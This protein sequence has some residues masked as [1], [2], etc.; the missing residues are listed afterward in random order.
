MFSC[1]FL[2]VLWFTGF[3]G[4]GGFERGHCDVNDHA[5]EENEEILLREDAQRCDYIKKYD[6][7]LT[8]CIINTIQCSSSNT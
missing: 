1:S 7:A 3:E 8:F 6:S 5:Y 4:F 2:F